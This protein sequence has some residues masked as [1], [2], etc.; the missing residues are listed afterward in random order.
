MKGLIRALGACILVI[1]ILQSCSYNHGDH[2]KSVYK[3]TL[4]D[5]IVSNAIT[6]GLEV[7][8]DGYP[9]TFS[10]Y[11]KTAS[12][13]ERLVLAH[14]KATGKFPREGMY[15]ATDLR[16]Y[17]DT[18]KPYERIDEAAPNLYR[19]SLNRDTYAKLEVLDGCTV[20]TV[21]D[22]GRGSEDDGGKGNDVVLNVF[23]GY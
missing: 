4:T 8:Y 1:G 17:S 7:P 21:Y 13:I 19:L 18:S 10:T 12:S 22:D 15:F 14:Y 20:F 6:G 11:P 23:V 9:M 3:F 5:T 16:P 2:V